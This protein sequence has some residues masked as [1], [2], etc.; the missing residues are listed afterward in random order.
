MKVNDI[1][2]NYDLYKELEQHFRHII[3]TEIL[4]DVMNSEKHIP[5]YIVG[6]HQGYI[7]RSTE[8][9]LIISKYL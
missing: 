2:E 4:A 5:P 1:I 8:V 3:A 9:E 7:T 6:F